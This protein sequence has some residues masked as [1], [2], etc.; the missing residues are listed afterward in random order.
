M[1]V[2]TLRMTVAAQPHYNNG[3]G[4]LILVRHGETEGQ[5]SV[6]YHG[7]GNVAL[8]VRGRE[9]MR[10]A[11]RLLKGEVFTRVFASSLMRATEG[12]RIIAGDDAQVIAIDEFVEIDFGDF[13]GLTI[14]RFASGIPTSLSDG[15]SGGWRRTT[16]IRAARAARRSGSASRPGCGGCLSCGATDVKNSAAPRCWL[17]IAASSG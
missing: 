8:D 7:R 16:N 12:A 5:S 17:R 14:D 2:G 9:Q 15:K 1:T 10:A 4:R 3:A 11:A 13:E 6:R